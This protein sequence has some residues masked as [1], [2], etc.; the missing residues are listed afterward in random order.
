MNDNNL[1]NILNQIQEYSKVLFIWSG[2]TVPDYLKET[3]EK[4]QNKAQDIKISVEHSERLSLASYGNSAFDIIISNILSP[5]NVKHDSK[6]LYDYL[7]FLKPKGILVTFEIIENNNI[8]VEQIESEYK[9]NGFINLKITKSDSGLVVVN[10]EKPNFEVG[11]TRKLNFS[12]KNNVDAA[13]PVANKIWQ[14]NDDDI[15]E[16][17][18]INTDDLLDEADLKKPIVNLDKFDCGTTDNSTGKRKA[19]KN[20]SCGLAEELENEVI[21]ERAAQQKQPAAKSACGSCFLGDAFRCASCPYLGMPA[22]KPG[23]KIQLTERQLKG[24]N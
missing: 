8:T 3:I 13:K 4:L 10:A 17:D 9:L 14:L 23:E 20:C 21:G 15:G 5:N 2:Q 18:L 16:S 19:C 22:F 7:K 1:N 24:D 6:I 12:K 11:S